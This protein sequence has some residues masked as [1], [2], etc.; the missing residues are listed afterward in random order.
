MNVYFRSET[1]DRLILEALGGVLDGGTDPGTVF[2]ARV[3][4]YGGR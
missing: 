2:V 3:P 1:L 4:T